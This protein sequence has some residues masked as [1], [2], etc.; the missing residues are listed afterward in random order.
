M[1]WFYN[2]NSGEL[3]SESGVNEIGFQLALHTGTGWHELNIPAGD[4]FA[5]AAAYVAKTSPGT[6]APTQSA[7][8]GAKNVTASYAAQATGGS[9]SSVQNALSGFYDKVTDGKM[10]RS[11]GW[12]LLGI[13]LMIAGV[14]LWIGPS[15]AR[16]SPIGIATEALG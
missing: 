1:T 16:R 14:A 15:A 4:T 11:L 5:Q 9:F 2:S 3:V 8:Q 12:L 7:S 6:P 13:A 10:W